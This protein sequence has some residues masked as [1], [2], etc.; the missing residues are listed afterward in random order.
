M[1]VLVAVPALNESA[2]I[3]GVLDSLSQV[4][5]LTDVVIVDDGSRDNTAQIA[6]EAGA[7][8]VEHA[9]NLGVG[10]AMGTAFK[11]AVRNGYDAVIQFDGDGQHRPEHIQE[12]VAALGEADI[13]IGSRFADGGSYKSSAAR[14]GVQRFIA[15]VVSV[16]A[17]TRLTD[18]TSGFRIAGPRAV[19]VFAEHYPVEWLGDTVESIVLA[20]RQDLTVHEIPVAMNERAGGVPSQSVFRATLYTARILFILGLASIRSVPPQLRTLRGRKHKEVAA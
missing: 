7:R 5:P 15:R 19:A 12:L 20:T 17:R 3:G 4:H 13:V 9:I 14:R 6:K 10:A 8:V 11:Y 2:V 16:Y 18:A 1:R